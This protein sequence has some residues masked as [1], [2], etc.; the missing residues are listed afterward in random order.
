MKPEG[1]CLGEICVPVPGGLIDGAVNV[2]VVAEKLGMPIVH[3]EEAGLWG[4]GSATFAGHALSSATA[5]ELEL[6]DWKGNTFQL[7][8]LR[9]KKVVV[10]SWAPY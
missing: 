3:D 8:S 4:I 10:I 6:P 5:P 9:G 2:S 1:A 7:S